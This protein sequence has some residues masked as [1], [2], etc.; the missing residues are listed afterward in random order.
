VRLVLCVVDWY[1][2][3]SSLNL[4]SA[5]YAGNAFVRRLWQPLVSWFTSSSVMSLIDAGQRSGVTSYAALSSGITSP[6]SRSESSFGCVRMNV[7]RL[8]GAGATAA[9]AS[10]RFAKPE[11][12]CRRAHCCENCAH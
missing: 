2:S 6:T 7:W 4:P 3:C 8:T 12:G 1:T 5:E 11:G 10:R 9:A